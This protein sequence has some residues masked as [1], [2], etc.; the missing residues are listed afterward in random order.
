MMWVSGGCRGAFHCSGHR[1][2][3]CGI[4]GSGVRTL[5]SCSK[6]A[7]THKLPTHELAGKAA[8][9]Q[10]VPATPPR[11]VAIAYC[12]FG[13]AR[14]FDEGAINIHASLSKM[15][16]HPCQAAD[17][18][19]HT[20]RP[21]SNESYL[22]SNWKGGED[23]R[24]P[25]RPYDFVQQLV[26]LYNPVSMRIDRPHQFNNS[27]DALRDTPTFPSAT[28]P[29]AKNMAN[30]FSSLYSRWRVMLLLRD[31]VSL[32]NL[33]Y[34]LVFASRFDFINPIT[35]DVGTLNP[36]RIY[37]SN[38]HL[39]Q[40][41]RHILPPDCVVTGLPLFL[42]LF[43]LYP[44]LRSLA[45]NMSLHAQMAS[46]RERPNL[47]TPESLL[48]MQAFTLVSYSNGHSSLKHLV[49]Y[50]GAIP[51]Y[52]TEQQRDERSKTTAEAPT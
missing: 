38:L 10:A 26:Q 27:V 20:W 13:Q 33:Q 15:Q 44:R 40:R 24:E 2:G 52:M 1:N 36:S 12:L 14:F 37:V 18:Y 46:I 35:L 8:L 41:G 3:I 42:E 11:C 5:C 31:A 49:V 4:K 48:T 30:T 7:T 50:T 23:I 47:A 19:I 28:A 22:R 29:Q 16:P 17:F 32:R 51:N 6:N 39:V 9:R 34:D 43:D 25:A 45:T 21:L